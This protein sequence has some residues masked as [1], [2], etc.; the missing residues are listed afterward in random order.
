MTAIVS[1][2]TTL[3]IQLAI[4]FVVLG[5]FIMGLRTITIA[6]DMRALNDTPPTVQEPQ[7]IKPIPGPR[8]LQGLQGIRGMDG[9][10]GKNGK[11]GQDGTQGPA[12]PQGET[13]SPAQQVEL[14]YNPDTF[15]LECKLSGDTLWSPVPIGGTC[16]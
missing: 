3:L 12:G 16:P 13:G 11:N 14:R 7:P 4:I 9:L 15:Q 5:V 10:D 1:T 2:K 6:N 8:G